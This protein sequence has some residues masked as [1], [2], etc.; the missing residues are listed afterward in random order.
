MMKASSLS[1]TLVVRKGSA[2]PS[3]AAPRLVVPG[4]GPAA[5]VKPTPAFGQRKATG[6]APQPYPPATPAAAPDIPR[7]GRRT[8]RGGG[9]VRMT[10]RLQA[11]DHLR[12]KLAAAHTGKNMTVLIE[13]AIERYLAAMGPRVNGGHCACIAGDLVRTPG[14]QPGNDDGDG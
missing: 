10:L 4:D 2:A 7:P 13:D 8:T 5:T 3:V 9:K 1:S 14:E 11:A 6:A 12:L